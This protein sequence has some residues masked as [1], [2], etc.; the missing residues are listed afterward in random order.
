LGLDQPGSQVERSFSE[1]VTRG[2]FLPKDEA[3]RLSAF[4]E[5]RAISSDLSTAGRG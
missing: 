5:G 2:I 4:A 3:E 1:Q